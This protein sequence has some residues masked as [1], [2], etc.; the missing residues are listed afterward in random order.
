MVGVEL[1]VIEVLIDVELNLEVELVVVV[2]VTAA[3][4]VVELGDVG[5]DE[6]VVDADDGFVVVVVCCLASCQDWW[7]SSLS[8]ILPRT[9]PFQLLL[10]PSGATSALPGLCLLVARTRVAATPLRGL[11][12]SCGPATKTTWP[13]WPAAG[14]AMTR[15]RHSRS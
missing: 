12:S 1:D 14:R 2:V 8:F 15:S 11:W 3:E 4:L 7:R 9:L 6:L 10:H 5:V 13:P